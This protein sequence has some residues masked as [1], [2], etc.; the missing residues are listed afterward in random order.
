MENFRKT[1][2]VATIG[3]ASCS[4][5]NIE[6]LIA[7]GANMF[8]LNFSHGDHAS[9][10]AVM[11]AIKRV[12]EKLGVSVGIMQ[13]LGG[14][15]IRLGEISGGSIF[16]ETGDDMIIDTKLDINCGKRFGTNYRALATDVQPNT[17]L[18]LADGIIECEIL[19]T[20]ETEIFCK[21]V[22]GGEL[23]SKKGIAYPEGSFSL[24][25]LTEKD[26]IDLDFGLHAGIDF[27]ALS[28]VRNVQDIRET[29]DF[30]AARGFDVPIFAK[31]EKHEAISALDEIV[32]AAD[33]I[34]VARGDLGVEM[35]IETVPL[36]QKRII[37]T[38]NAYAIP[39]ITATQMLLSMVH[40]PRPTRAEITDIANAVLDGTDA[41]MLSEETAM[42]DHP[43]RAVATM[44]KI[45]AETEKMPQPIRDFNFVL[46]CIDCADERL[47]FALTIAHSAALLAERSHAKAIICPTHTGLTAKLV[48]SFRAQ[49]PVLALT[50]SKKVFYRLSAFCGVFPQ[51]FPRDETDFESVIAQAEQIA[52]QRGCLSADDNYVITAGLPFGSGLPTNA[53]KL[54]NAGESISTHT[55]N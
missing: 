18:L 21:V 46:Q 48:A 9:H 29:R 28:F 50:T 45:C 53:L 26:K 19:R 49:V 41:V 52:I 51:L 36:L 11:D 35:P 34:I 14:P 15:K 4:E 54:C 24:P 32:A 12:R 20:T 40:E 6:K 44:A 2:I 10:G 23:F 3:P 17:R 27:V 30:I 42:G 55:S 25:A 7:A 39:V 5:E 37:A 47:F 38:A 1:K 22:F 31:I 8:R 33:G 16:L 13:D 43:V